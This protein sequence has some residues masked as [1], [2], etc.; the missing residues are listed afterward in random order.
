MKKHCLFCC[1]GEL[2]VISENSLSYAIRDIKP[3]TD[4]HTLIISKRHC[5][6]ILDLSGD[7]FASILAL[8]KLCY[9]EIKVC[10]SSVKGFNFGS[11]NGSVAGQKIAHVH[12]HLI[13]RRR[14]DIPPP[15]AR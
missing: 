4:L 2:K 5:E 9:Q 7:E 3:V 8:A 10:D 11:N 14:G 6:T 15:P 13:P 12:F 1:G